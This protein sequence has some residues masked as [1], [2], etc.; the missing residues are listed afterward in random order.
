MATRCQIEF[1]NTMELSPE[2]AARIYKHYDSGPENISP[3]LRELEKRLRNNR[4]DAERAAA[5]FIIH[6]PTN[7]LYITQELHGDISYLYRI[8][9]PLVQD[10]TG[11]WEYKIYSCGRNNK[12]TELAHKE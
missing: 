8:F 7:D 2:P 6:F 12:L 11:K 1:Y 9:G 5:Q 4:Y 10:G 3:M